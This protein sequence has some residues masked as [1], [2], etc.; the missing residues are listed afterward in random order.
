LVFQLLA[1][2]ALVG[3]LVFIHESGH[4]IFAKIFGVGVKVFSLGFG[5]RLFGVEWGGTDYRVS[6][7]PA[8][9]Y[10]MMEGADPFQDG[11]DGDAASDSPTSFMN[12]PVWQRLIIVAAGPAFNLLL[13]VVVFTALFMV[14]EPGAAPVLGQVDLYSSAQDAG[15]QVGDRVTHIN[16]EEIA[17]WGAL[18][19]SL[20]HIDQDPIVRLLRGEQSLELTL[21]TPQGAILDGGVYPSSV[22]GISA[23]FPGPYVVVSDP[24]SVLARA[25]LETGD[26]ITKVGGEEIRSFDG[27]ISKLDGIQGQAEVAYMRRDTMGDVVDGSITVTQD[28]TRPESSLL[29]EHP[30]ANAWGLAPPYLSVYEVQSESPAEVGGLLR[31]DVVTAVDGVK[32]RTFNDVIHLVKQAQVGEGEVASTRAVTLTLLRDGAL[33]DRIFK[34]TIREDHDNFGRYTFRPVIG[35]NTFSIGIA[36]EEATRRYSFIPALQHAGQRTLDAATKVISTVGYLVTGEAAAS[37]TVGGPIAIFRHA[38][39]AAE[40]GIF[41]WAYMMAGLSISL[42]VVNFLPVPVLDGGQFL[43]YAVEGIR[44]RPLS[45]LVRERAQQVGVLFLL[46]LMFVVL[47]IDVRNWIAA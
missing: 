37:K 38:A 2:R 34:P 17:T 1:A 39:A 33:Q 27:L 44:G 22:Y 16:G 46:G 32:V 36:Q 3:I 41:D 6:L 30:H 24:D 21:D 8:G 20:E 26:L 10:V 29:F 15:L 31:G 18:E 5:R 28:P 4:F 12:K 7:I 14:G 19:E 42:A 40:R 11:G 23:I 13:P 43:F 45:L 25:G 9:G 47:V 35:F